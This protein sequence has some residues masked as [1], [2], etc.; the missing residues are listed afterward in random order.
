MRRRD[1][2]ALLGCASASLPF[3]ARAQQP[4]RIGFLSS[5][6]PDESES[7]VSAFRKGLFSTGYIEGHNATVD[8]R[9][10][11]GQYD[12]LSALAAELV[13]RRVDIIAATGDIVSALAAK[14]AP[15]L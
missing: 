14:S 3:P 10:A 5:R 1:F 2:I 9:W 6:S 11:H 4:S 7:V 13:D 12:R 8:F 15:E